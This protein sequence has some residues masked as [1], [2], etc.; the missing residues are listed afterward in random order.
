VPSSASSISLERKTHS[1]ASRPERL[2]RA[3]PDAS[4][5]AKWHTP[6]ETGWEHAQNFLAAFAAGALRLT[7][8]EHLKVEVIRTLYVAL[9]EALEI[10]FV[11][12]DRRLFNLAKQRGL[13]TVRR[14]EDV[15][16]Q[17][18]AEPAEGT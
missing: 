6:T 7:A 5:V 16:P 12:A 4:L 17:S 9:A 18:Q 8:P 10:P 3:V 13:T 14:F 2:G 11:T 15:S 1:V